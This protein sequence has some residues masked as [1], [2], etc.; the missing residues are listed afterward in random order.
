MS[1]RIL[2]ALMQ[3]FAIIAKVEVTDF[4]EF[5]PEE[6]TKERALVEVFLKQELSP[7]QVKAYL[8]IFDECL[9]LHHTSNKKK[10]GNQKRTSLNSVKILRICNQINSELTHKQRIIVLVRILEFIYIKETITSQEIDFVTTVAESFNIHKDEFVSIHNFIRPDCNKFNLVDDSLLLV[11]KIKPDNSIKHIHSDGM[12]NGNHIWILRIHSANLLFLKYYGNEEFYLNGQLIANDRFQI[13]TQGS[14]IRSS[15][16]S[17]IYYSDIISLYLLGAS[18]ERFIFKTDNLI[19][20]FSHSNYGIRNLNFEQQNGKLLGV[21]GG[22]GAGKSTLLNILNGNIKPTKGQVTINGIDIHNEREKIQ[23][24]IGNISQDDILIEEL[25]VFQ[26]LYFNAQLSFGNLTNRQISRKVVNLLSALGLYEIKDLKVGNHLEKTISGGQRKRL[27]IALELIREPA[28]LFVDEPTSGLSSRD[29]E[30]IMDLLKEL[31][32]KGKLVIVVIHQP[33]SEIYKMFDNLLILDQGGYPIYNGNPIDAVVYFKQA[34]NHANSQESEC[35]LCGNVNPEQIFN[36]IESK[37]VDEFGQQ[38]TDRKIPPEEWSKLYLSSSS[39][40][41]ETVTENVTPKSSFS[42]PT[43]LKQFRIFFKRDLL[44]KLTNQQYVLINLLEAPLLAAILSF[45]IKYFTTDGYLFEKNENIPQYIFI[46]VIISL[47][48]GLTVA[49]EE[50]I[51][52]KKIKKRESFLNLSKSSYLLSKISLLFIIS[53]IQSLLLVF[54]GNFILGIQNMWFEYWLV[55]FSVSCFANLTGLNISAS[56]N[57][58]KVIY[59]LI[60]LIIIPQLLFSGLIVKFD[61]LHPLFKNEK[62][63][64]TIGNLMASRWAYEAIAV[65]QFKDNKFQQI[66]YELEKEKSLHEWRRDYLIPS[67]LNLTNDIAQNKS[68]KDTSILVLRNELPKLFNDWDNIDTPVLLEELNNETKHKSTSSTIERYLQQIKKHHNELLIQTNF[69]IDSLIS[70][71]SQEEYKEIRSAH[72]NTSLSDQVTNRNDLDKLLI[73]DNEIIQKRNPIY[74]SNEEA[75]LS[76]HLFSPTKRFIGMQ[77]STFF[78]NIMVIWFMTL[79]LTI[80]LYF[81]T[82]K[83]IVSGCFKFFTRLK[84]V[85]KVVY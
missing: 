36:I 69:R 30:N 84:L 31:T 15:R 23:G 28:V 47:F 4:A 63:V 52:D 65:T 70:T 68:N 85:K 62:S 58:A 64:P 50:I 20:K 76:A 16:M 24:V 49:A 18:S 66:F 26:N 6:A 74:F 5:N 10:D 48:I 54:V 79:F 75:L 17:T 46:A 8:K 56:F 21:M 12:I 35:R 57:S 27:N 41:N 73:V 39:C 83:Q 25:T 44:S 2:K 37:V 34:I 77:L 33:S 29:S 22:S 81:N 38:T 40:S 72:Y 7:E 3:L 80:T 43:Q 14:S 59:I 53:A 45:F 67:L 60:P 11:S 13:L 55:F 82:L 9:V 78:V 19:Y 42:I 71:F 61:K 32:L 1:E 51:K